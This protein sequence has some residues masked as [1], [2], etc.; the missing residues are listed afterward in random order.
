MGLAPPITGLPSGSHKA[1]LSGM[2]LQIQLSEE[3][4]LATEPRQEAGA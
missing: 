1:Y 3:R 4:A 2:D